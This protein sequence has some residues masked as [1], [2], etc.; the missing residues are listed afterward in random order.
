MKFL[1][2]TGALAAA[3]AALLS[4]NASAVNVAGDG[5]GEVA[6][7]PY[8]TVRDGWQTLI[9][10]TNTSPDPIV[11]KVRFHEALNSRD[12]LDFNVAL[13]GYDVFIGRLVDSDNGPRFIGEDSAD[14]SGRITCT[15]PSSV[16]LNSQTNNI[17]NRNTTGQ[18]MSTAGFSGGNPSSNDTGPVGVD[19][20]RE[21]YVEFV[22]MG[23]TIGTKDSSYVA[24]DPTGV[25]N[26]GNA[27][28]NHDCRALD[29][30]F[31]PGSRA[32]VV[33]GVYGVDETV[34][35]I[36]DQATTGSDSI[37]QIL[38]TARQFGEPINALKYNFRLVNP[39]RGTEAGGAASVWGNFYNTGVADAPMDAAN[40]AATLADT[41]CVV[42]RGDQR[43]AANANLWQPGG[44]LALDTAFAAVANAVSCPNLVTRQFSNGFLEP[45][46]NDAFPPEAN[47][48]DDSLNQAVSVQ[49]DATYTNVAGGLRG[50]DAMSATI[51]RSAIN[52]EWANVDDGD[53]R[54]VS[55][56][57]IVT[58]PT[59]SFYVDRGAGVQFGIP[60]PIAAG[61]GFAGSRGRPEADLGQPGPG[62]NVAT[63]ARP[64]MVAYPPFQNPFNGA[65]PNEARAC[66][67]VEFS[68]FDRAEQAIG[69]AAAGGPVVSPA[70]PPDVFVAQLCYESNVITFDGVSAL[71]FRGLGTGF[72]TGLNRLLANYPS[73]PQNTVQTTGL[74]APNNDNGWVSMNLTAN[75]LGFQSATLPLDPTAFGGN[76][77]A[78]SAMDGLP[79]IGFLLKLRNRNDATQN[80]ASAAD[81]GYGRSLTP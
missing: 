45:S 40:I 35:A 32:E 44:A 70:P 50:I 59:K 25:I 67:E 39:A 13:S 51:M 69:Q 79:V 57:W 53:T 21:G 54:G 11:V 17:S 72:P 75:S 66:N 42:T 52:N 48:W 37:R 38:A 19:R 26:V 3:A 7:A 29:G 60:L 5:V 6:I 80:Y 56:D 68:V 34:A 49:P 47:W 77:Q 27:I 1:R 55:T 30:A 76:G 41:D 36:D 28:E 62:V 9:N 10:L 65:T 33:G 15:I 74:P 78:L 4:Q 23:R 73:G 2:S 43:E 20:L 12:V 58:M 31:G 63:V 61:G 16:V 22:V 64:L 24:Q 46:L 81:H 18:L 8:Y 14:S 71:G